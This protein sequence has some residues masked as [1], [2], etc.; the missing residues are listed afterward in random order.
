VPATRVSH[1]VQQTNTLVPLND[2]QLP[3]VRALHVQT[4][5][6]IDAL[7][8]PFGQNGSLNSACGCSLATASS[9][10]TAP[11]TFFV[12]LLAADVGEGWFRCSPPAARRRSSVGFDRTD[13]GHIEFLKAAHEQGSYVVAGVH[14][15]EVVNR[16]K[17]SNHPIMALHERVLGILSCRV[18]RGTGAAAICCGN[19]I[20]MRR[21]DRSRV[22]ASV[23]SMSTTS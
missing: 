7:L 21:G 8:R 12:R 20:L 2:G 10:W 17:G 22:P 18:G 14:E 13:V 11:L 15:D 3:A 9:T 19:F 6:D 4:K 5:A 23:P 1:Y 16:V